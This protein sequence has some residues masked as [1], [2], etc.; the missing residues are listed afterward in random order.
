[1]AATRRSRVAT[2]AWRAA[3]IVSSTI[4]DLGSAN[5]TFVNDERVDAQRRR[6]SGDVIRV[7]TTVLEVIAGAVAIPEPGRRRAPAPEPERAPPDVRRQADAVLVITA[8][9][10]LD[11]RLRV[12]DELVL[13][14]EAG[15]MEG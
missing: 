1:M 9:S 12:R 10:G 8:G 6:S 3:P 7:G 15:P 5:G 2:H 11:R 4:E 13:G 14:R